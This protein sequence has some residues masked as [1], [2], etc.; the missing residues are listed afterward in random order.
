MFDVADV[1]VCHGGS[2]TTYGAL[3]DGLP[4]VL[5]PIFADQF[6]NAK[7]VTAVGAA[8]TVE[9]PDA[10]AD[11]IRAVL[12]STSYRDRAR[13]FATEMA[14]TPSVDDV[15]DEVLARAG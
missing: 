12:G 11:G 15:L 6:E 14:E 13:A 3:A 4:L 2:G 8:I 7:R 1:V 5:V 10:I 9:G